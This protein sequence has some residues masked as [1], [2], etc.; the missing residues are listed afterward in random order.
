M[1]TAR[2]HPATPA[3]SP[4]ATGRIAARVAACAAARAR[5]TRVIDA[6]GSWSRPGFIDCTRTSSRCWRCRTPR[7]TCGRASPRPRQP[8]R[9]RERSRSAPYLDSLRALGIGMNV[10]FLVGHNT[11][12]QRSA[13]HGGPAPTEASCAACGRW[14]AAMDR[15]RVRPL[16]R[17]ALHARLLRDTDE[18]VAL[19]EVAARAAAS[20][21]RT[22]ATRARPDRRRARGHRDR[23]PRRHSGRAHAPQGGRRARCGAER[24]HAGADRLRARRRHRRHGRSVSLHGHAHR[25]QH[26]GAAVGARRRQPRVPARLDDPV[27]RDSIVAG[28]IWNI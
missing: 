21:R 26:S 1:S 12:R 2:V 19:A 24:A 11:V 22:C 3:T 27:L 20:T 14:C 7:A 8:G 13:G 10:G 16:H 25:H 5:P 6:R 15:R 9:R 18:V 28:I 4:C 17:A 23:T